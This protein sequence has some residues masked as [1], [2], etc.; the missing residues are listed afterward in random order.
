VR[1]VPEWRTPENL[2]LARELWDAG[3]STREI[4]ARFGVGKDMIIGHAHRHGWPR[5]PKSTRPAKPGVAR[6]PKPY[7][8]PGRPAA[9]VRAAVKPQPLAVPTPRFAGCQWI[10]GG[11]PWVMCGAPTVT[12][13]S[14]WCAAH[15]ARAFVR[16]SSLEA[17]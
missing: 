14:P 3:V 11:R 12:L 13:A 7:R 16:R 8:L 10:D 5:H 2:A 1:A 9:E 6:V 15:R 4:G 17:S